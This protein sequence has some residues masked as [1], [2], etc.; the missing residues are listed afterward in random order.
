MFFRALYKTSPITASKILYYRN[1]KKTLNLE[2]PVNFNEKLQWLKHYW[3][4]P[5]V[6]ECADKY[7]LHEYVKKCGIEEILNELHGVYSHPSEINWDD[8]PNEFALKCTHGCGYNIICDDK[9]SLDKDQAHKKLS[10]WLNERYG[11]VAGELHYDKMTPR[12]IAEKYIE[13]DAGLLP[14]DYKIYCFNGKAKLALV[15]S[16]RESNLK[17]N[18]VDIDWNRMDIGVSSFTSK[19]MP[20]KPKCF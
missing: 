8:L 16:D 7:G 1:T 2:N 14:N 5:L 15:C 11:V 3:Q 6:S 4:H 12:I 10:S 17:L 19:E 20:E 9:E 18:F 13:T